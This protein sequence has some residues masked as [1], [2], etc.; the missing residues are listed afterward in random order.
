[1]KNRLYTYLIFLI[2]GLV[3]V[4]T[5]FAQETE[6]TD[7]DIITL[8]EFE[9][10]E[11]AVRGWIS[12]QTVSG[13]RSAQLLVDVP[14]HINIATR[15]FLDDLSPIN[16][17]AAVQYASAGTSNK[18][19]WTDDFY[20]R[21]YRTTFTSVDGFESFNKT[22]TPDI[23]AERIEIVNGPASILYGGAAENGGTINRVL[24][25]P[26]RKFQGQIKFEIG[27]DNWYGGSFDV[28][29]P[30]GE[31]EGIQ[32]RFIG[33]LRNG[34]RTRFG[35]IAK[36]DQI[37]FSP[38]FSIDI[39]KRSN[40][41]IR[42]RYL[43]RKLGD[44]S[45][46]LDPDVYPQVKIIDN[47]TWNGPNSRPHRSIISH[48]IYA[49]FTTAITDNIAFRLAFLVQR[50]KRPTQRAVGNTSNLEDSPAGGL[51]WNVTRSHQNQTHW[52][53]YEA[54]QGDIVVKNR[55]GDNITSRFSVGGEYR[56][57]SQDF[58]FVL[59]ISNAD[60][61]VK[62]PTYPEQEPGAV[63][64]DFW[65]FFRFQSRA[66]AFTG[67]FAQESLS[68]W[69]GRFAI[70]G[71]VRWNYTHTSRFM[72]WQGSDPDAGGID[73]VSGFYD[74]SNPR[75]NSPGGTL[76]VW[77]GRWGVVVKPFKEFTNLSF[78]AGFN[79]TFQPAGGADFEGK[80]FG[81]TRAENIEGGVK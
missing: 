8:S 40:L 55:L 34:D 68:F 10:S 32:Y 81:P 41:V 29:G 73:P 30:F 76:A 59:P 75:D 77:T 36:D 24:K 49:N 28:T 27:T 3:I 2:C 80:L 51:T 33:E 45:L 56:Q 22:I 71:G 47:V 14:Q 70:T 23:M 5:G 66:N 9:V 58:L 69:D 12:T 25:T 63:F 65:R 52:D 15:D 13:L 50:S 54:V 31:K 19:Q 62:A 48:D 26:L 37:V 57:N 11:D 72:R 38:A 16:A 61:D 60:F 7:E 46:F 18:S 67:L 42:Y 35:D 79:E 64:E 21:G 6:E 74:P 1:M 44:T 39:G 43:G 4:T 53:N 17:A 20:I 78:F